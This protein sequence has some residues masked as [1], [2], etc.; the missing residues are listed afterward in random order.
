MKFKFLV[1]NSI[2]IV[3]IIL[4]VL[5]LAGSGYTLYNMIMFGA[6]AFSIISIIFAIMVLVLICLLLFNTF[7]HFKEDK[8]V[9]SLGIFQQGI[10][11]RDIVK[12][13]NYVNAKE[14]FILFI[15]KNQKQV[16][17]ISQ[18]MINIKPSEYKTFS[19]A[20]IAKNANIIYD[21]IDKNLDEEK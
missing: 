15:P 4:S 13:K 17:D 3:L 9:V 16:D 5:I 20:L 10:D 8:L 14:L 12:I 6:S 21:E 1:K 2:T 7:Y 19:D 18:I 11:Y